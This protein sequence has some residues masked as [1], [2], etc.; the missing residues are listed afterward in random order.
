MI[1]RPP[2]STLFPYTTLFRSLPFAAGCA[3]NRV[4]AA[5]AA[6]LDARS[7]SRRYSAEVGT[8]GSRR[9]AAVFHHMDRPVNSGWSLPPS[10]R[11][12]GLYSES[13]LPEPSPAA[14]T[15]SRDTRPT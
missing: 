5:S 7:I 9:R 3:A 8:H 13:L 4:L 14:L 12:H 10:T 1:R 15:P 2:R 11:F 6:A